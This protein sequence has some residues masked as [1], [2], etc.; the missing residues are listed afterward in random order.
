M[1]IN[2]LICC[3]TYLFSEG[4]KKL[5]DDENDMSITCLPSKRT[6][7]EEKLKISHDTIIISD[8]DS[9]FNC[10]AGIHMEEGINILIIQ[11]T[12]HK[13]SINDIF[14]E[15]MPKGVVGMLLPEIDSS[16]LKKALRS[17]YSGDLWF[18]HKTIKAMLSQKKAKKLTNKEIEIAN[19]VCN[20]LKNKEIACKLNITEQTV[21]SHLNRIYK[22]MGVTDRLQLALHHKSSA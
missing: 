12:S 7:V 21:K 22:K 20:G 17:V 6:D 10:F 2:V 1:Q 16:H 5:L 9:F 19:H 4:L 8:I 14:S 18:N 3:H 15:T 13:L 11:N